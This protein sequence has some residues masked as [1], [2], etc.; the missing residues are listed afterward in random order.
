[1]APSKTFNIAGLMNSVIVISSPELRRLFEEEILCLHL[2]LGNIFGHVTFEAAYKHG[3][4]WLDEMIGYLEKNIE[5]N[6][7]NS[8]L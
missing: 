7:L 5:Y 6:R 3:D 4:A 8:F 1:M 2:D